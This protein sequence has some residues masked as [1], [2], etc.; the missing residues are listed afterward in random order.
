M[1]CISLDILSQNYLQLKQNAVNITLNDF[2]HLLS[3]PLI[4]FT[5]CSFKLITS[6]QCGV[7]ANGPDITKEFIE[8]YF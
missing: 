1:F 7:G 8:Q 4:L 6:H 2:E 3:R 5:N